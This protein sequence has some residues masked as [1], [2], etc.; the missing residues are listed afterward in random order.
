MTDCYWNGLSVKTL[1][2]RHIIIPY[3]TYPSWPKKT[4]Q[5]EISHSLWINPF[6][7][8]EIFIL[9]FFVE[10]MLTLDQDWWALEVICLGNLLLLSFISAGQW[11]PHTPTQQ[12]TNT[13]G[14]PEHIHEQ[15]G[16]SSF[17]DESRGAGG[18]INVCAG[19][20][21]V[22]G[23]KRMKWGEYVPPLLNSA[24]WCVT[25]SKDFK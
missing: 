16:L 23:T 13:V 11:A 20:Q 1:L 21:K 18:I 22:V 4:F 9:L 2:M 15:P 6:D 25:K 12:T 24:Q 10:M 7:L 17:T 14:I 5:K 3:Y 19:K 8:V